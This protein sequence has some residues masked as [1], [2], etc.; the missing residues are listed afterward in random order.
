MGMRLT[1]ERDRMA[2]NKVL[3]F[4]FHF[5]TLFNIVG[6]Q[7]GQVHKISDLET[8]ESQGSSRGWRC[9]IYSDLA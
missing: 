4:L 7:L 9:Q 2:H 5:A 8:G 1:E 3:P 6:H